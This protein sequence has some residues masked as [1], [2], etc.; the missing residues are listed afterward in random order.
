M[1]KYWK[2]PPDQNANFVAAM[3]DILEVYTRPYDVKFP[4][5]CMDESSVQLIGEV[6]E[7]IPELPAMIPSFVT[8]SGF[9]RLQPSW[10]SGSIFSPTWDPQSLLESIRQ[11]RA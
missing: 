7:S 3:E 11:T 8:G 4:V 2:I 6:H 9:S 1:S 10:C 5:V